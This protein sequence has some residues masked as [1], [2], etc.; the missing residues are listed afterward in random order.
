MKK[1]IFGLVL[2]SAVMG[3]ST[4]SAADGVVVVPLSS[5]PGW[6]IQSVNHVYSIPGTSFMPLRGYTQTESNGY[7]VTHLRPG[8]YLAGTDLPFGVSHHKDGEKMTFTAPV[9][10]PDGAQVG[11]IGAAVCSGDESATD[12]SITFSLVQ[13][14]MATAVNKSIRVFTV[15]RTLCNTI[16]ENSVPA[17]IPLPVVIDNSK[18]TYEFKVSGLEGGTCTK[19]SL[20]TW[21]CDPR[22]TRLQYAQ[23]NYSTEDVVKK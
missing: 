21:D 6:E 17:M 11:G 19:T 18:Y 4:V 13:T 12:F 3:G 7:E 1:N 16:Q 20:L 8:L 23:I 15:N 14:D 2:L 9:H 22:L 10:L 5:N